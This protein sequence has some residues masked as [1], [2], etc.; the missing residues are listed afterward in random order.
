MYARPDP[1][2]HDETARRRAPLWHRAAGFVLRAALP[3]AILLAGA[4]YAR[5]VY[6]GA[7]EAAR[8]AP[9]RR[10]RLVEVAAARAATTGPVLRAWGVVE[11]SRRLV[12]RPEIGGRA[13]EVSDRLTPGGEVAAGDVLLRLDDRQTRLEIAEAEA[14]IARI[15]AL[16]RQEAGQRDR[17]ERDLR[18]SPIRGGITD[19]QRALILREP[20]MAE[21]TAQ[22][23]AAMARRDAARLRAEKLTLTA[24]FDALVESETAARGTVLMAG[25]EIARLVATERF[26]VVAA[27]PPAALGWLT[28]PGAP[29]RVTLSQPGIWPE[30]QRRTARIAQLKGGLSA[31]GRMAE[32]ILEVEDPL[33]H[34][35]ANAPRLLL[36]SL[37]EARIEVPR[38]AEAVAIDPHWLRDGD[39]LWIAADGR[40]EIRPV[41][42]AW[43]GPDEALVTAGLAPGERIVTT[44]FAAAADGM[45]IR[46]AGPGG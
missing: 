13:L 23:D 9:E 11:P 31:V 1:M 16:I 43:R 36:G 20:Q 44:R 22:R 3:V 33:A 19:E 34:D 14:E 39:T 32:L 17:A 26:R 45:A 29:P 42:V 38:L 15:T 4:E 10:A 27:I 28:R 18:R 25:T 21:L 24:P 40:L 7:P 30:G 5:E 46:V 8:E 2:A 41:T 12:L 6:L 37:L 35:P